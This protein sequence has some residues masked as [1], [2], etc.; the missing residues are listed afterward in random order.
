VI[1]E[2]IKP[3]AEP[4]VCSWVDEQNDNHLYLSVITL[5]EIQKGIAKLGDG[6]KKSKLQAWL[7][8]E[9]VY[10]FE[11]RVLGIDDQTCKMWGKI[12][13]QSELK[14]KPLPVIDAMIAATALVNHMAV[15]TRNITDM[16]VPGLMIINPWNSFVES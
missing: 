4:V 7:D 8:T 12:L 14:G 13:A 10:R 5:G 16:T 3:K 11:G 9:L 2:L 1:S 15:A 6:T